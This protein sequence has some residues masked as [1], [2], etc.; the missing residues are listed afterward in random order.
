MHLKFTRA[1]SARLNEFEHEGKKERVE[2]RERGKEIA[3]NRI[4]RIKYLK[5]HLSLST[6]P[7]SHQDQHGGDHDPKLAVD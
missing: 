3:A 7:L 4:S 1:K 6:S 2:G 5:S